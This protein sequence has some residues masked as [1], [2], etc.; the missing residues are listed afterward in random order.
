MSDTRIAVILTAEE[1]REIQEHAAQAGMSESEYGYWRIFGSSGGELS[2]MH[3][4]HAQSNLGH[5]NSCVRRME[6]RLNNLADL[7][8]ALK[9]R[10]ISS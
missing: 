1:K 4:G 8:E 7:P 6:N 2:P 10:A 3:I 5:A 9:V